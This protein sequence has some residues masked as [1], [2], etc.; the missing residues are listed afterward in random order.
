MT[1]AT[2]AACP[3]LDACITLAWSSR[4]GSARTTRSCPAWKLQSKRQSSSAR[5]ARRPAM[6]LAKCVCAAVRSTPAD[7]SQF[8]A[9]RY[10]RHFMPVPLWP[11]MRQPAAR[12]KGDREGDD[13]RAETPAP[14]EQDQRTIRADRKNADQA[15]RKDSLILHKFESILSWAEFL[16]HQSPHR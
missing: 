4:R 2:L 6:S 9:P 1:R 15:A 16:N 3:G 8:T 13:A 14:D 10:Y 7:L 11:D 12:T 5:V